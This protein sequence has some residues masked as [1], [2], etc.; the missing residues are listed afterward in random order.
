MAIFGLSLFIYLRICT[1]GTG[2][3]TIGLKSPIRFKHLGV[4]LGYLQ[5]LIIVGV[6]SIGDRQLSVIL[7]DVPLN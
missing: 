4:F 1:S 5:T 7:K 3:K 6:I 2:A